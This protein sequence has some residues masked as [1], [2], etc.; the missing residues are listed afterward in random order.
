MS[1]YRHRDGLFWLSLFSIPSEKEKKQL[2]KWINE[3]HID[4]TAQWLASEML[5][6]SGMGHSEYRA[7]DPC[8]QAACEH[9]AL[10]FMLCDSNLAKDLLS[11]EELAKANEVYVRK[12]YNSKLLQKILHDFLNIL[13]EERGKNNLRNLFTISIID[14][15]R[16]VQEEEINRTYGA[17]K[18]AIEKVASGVKS[19]CYYEAEHD[20]YGFITPLNDSLNQFLLNKLEYN[21]NQAN[22]R[23]AGNGM[24]TLFCNYEQKVSNGIFQ[25]VM[26]HTVCA[27]QN[28]GGCGFDL[29]VV[30]LT[31]VLHIHLDF[32]GIGNGCSI[33]QGY[34]VT[35]HLFHRTDDI[36]K[37]AH[38][39][40]LDQN[41]IGMVG[42]NYLLQRLAKITHQTAANA[43]G[44]HL[45]N[46]DAGIL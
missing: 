11:E 7:D 26:I 28:N 45:G 29:V 22:E 25:L 18:K 34:I 16:K 31:K 24:S 13:I 32:A 42:I 40:G 12:Q 21:F 38:T 35:G 2:L 8:M 33:T 20:F 27:G 44:I 46:M 23:H 10:K 43:A 36:G 4:Y 41:P 17:L 15:L 39:G 14:E 9:V 30:E 37:L 5:G 1:M 3:R 19:N 6:L